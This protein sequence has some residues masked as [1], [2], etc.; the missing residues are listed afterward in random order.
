MIIYI[1]NEYKCHVTDDGNLTPVETDIFIGKCAAFIE[2]YRF[3]PDGC[4]WTRSDGE[5]YGGV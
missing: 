4:A 1:D 3:I 2:G 5:V